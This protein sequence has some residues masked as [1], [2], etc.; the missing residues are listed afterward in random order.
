MQELRPTL[1]RGAIA[2]AI[3]AV[4]VA[5]FFLIYDLIRGTPLNTFA[6]ITN[7]GAAPDP[8]DLSVLAVAVF[9]VIHFALFIAVGIAITWLIGRFYIRPHFLL[10]AVFGFLLFDLLFYAGSVVT[11]VNVVREIGWP[12]VLAA[13]V[14]AGIAMFA[15]LQATAPEPRSRG[16][17]SSQ[18]AV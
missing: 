11:G 1:A 5:L 3:G 15:Y 7:A 8:S 18:A 13:N 2:G 14:I 12:A 17:R 6:L 4:T 16:E 10:G 9:T